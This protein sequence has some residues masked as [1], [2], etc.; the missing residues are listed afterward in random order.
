MSIGA[1]CAA[2]AA[3]GRTGSGAARI[4]T[5]SRRTAVER[6]STGTSSEGCG[7]IIEG[8]RVLPRPPRYCRPADVRGWLIEREPV[9]PQRL[10]RLVEGAVLDRF[11]DAAV[12]AELVALS[13]FS[14]LGG[15]DQHDDGG[16]SGAR[17]RPQGAEHVGAVHA[18]EL[19]VDQHETG[20]GG[21]EAVP[22]ASAGEEIVERLLAVPRDADPGRRGEVAEGAQGELDLER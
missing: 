6:T 8:S 13:Q 1:A 16:R 11:P 3:R 2:R 12:G 9:A 21:A 20:Q 19:E 14:R 5:G 22:V 7:R 4:R 15:G 10:H 17:A 18:G